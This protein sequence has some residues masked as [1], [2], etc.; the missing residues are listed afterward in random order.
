VHK[1]ELIK[2]LLKSPNYTA[3]FGN[4]FYPAVN[5]THG[6]LKTNDLNMSRPPLMRER[7]FFV[8]HQNL[9]DVQRCSGPYFNERLPKSVDDLALYTHTE[10]REYIDTL[11]SNQ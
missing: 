9:S 2:C 1:N 10:K 6:Q 3:G 8:Q 5:T 4:T 11:R 7:L